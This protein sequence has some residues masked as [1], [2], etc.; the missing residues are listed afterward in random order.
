MVT[1]K[2]VA[3]AAGV[4]IT[5]VSHTIN[6]TRR[7]SDE[8]KARVLRAME[9][10]DYRPNV[11]ARS[12]RVGQTKTIGLII[13]DNSNLF[14]AEIARAIEDVGYQH[15]Y[16]VI[17]CNSDGQTDKQQQYV[18][19][20]VDKQVDGIVFISSGET[21]ED[22][23]NVIDNG[24]EVVVVD[25]DV[26]NVSADIV[27]V[28]NEL[29][30]YQATRYLIDLGHRRIAC[31][32]GPSQLTPSSHRVDGYRRAMQEAGL[33]VSAEY[34]VGGDFQIEGGETGIIKLLGLPSRPSAVFVCNDMMAIGVIRGARRLGLQIPED[35]SI[36]GFDNIALAR[37]TCPALTTMA[38]PIPDIARI[39]TELLIQRM[40]GDIDAPERQRI[41]LP[42]RLI[43]RESCCRCGDEA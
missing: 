26:P 7:V 14:F 11:L 4:S 19:T 35:L 31:I 41:V 21:A 18:Q 3:R 9:A 1:I 5:T 36:V 10:L 33:G 20:L 30:G 38:Q 16:S 12:L 15:G 29:A 24:I 37:A 42:A 32:S 27:L 23:Q 8:L 25:R 28:D 39:A 34:L 40:K 17:L 43:V 2:D 13:P 22:L 6:G